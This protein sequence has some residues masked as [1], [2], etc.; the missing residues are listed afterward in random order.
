MEREGGGEGVQGGR[1][2][3]RQGEVSEYTHLLIYDMNNVYT[4]FNLINICYDL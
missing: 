2:R 3:G 1:G 4:Y